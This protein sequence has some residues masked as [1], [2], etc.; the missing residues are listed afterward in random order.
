M[1]STGLP[2]LY[3]FA[4][5]FYFVLYWVYKILLLKYYERT[6]NFNEELPLF[7]TK[8]IKLGLIFH[9]VM[10]GLMT[11]NSDLMPAID[12]YAAEVGL[13]SYI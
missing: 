9:G 6:T 4:A 5:L 3:P 12:G 11:T 10:G 8:W 7:S 1:Y 13:T 2:I